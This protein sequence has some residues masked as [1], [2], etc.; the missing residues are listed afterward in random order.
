MVPTPQ[1]P[2]PPQTR[3]DDAAP[4]DHSQQTDVIVFVDKSQSYAPIVKHA[5]RIAGAFGGHII[6]LH[7]LV[8]PQDGVKPVDPVDWDIKRQ[9]TQNWL[10]SV[11]SEFDQSGHKSGQ[12]TES[13]LLEGQT[14]GQIAAH[15][16][17]RKGAVA[18]VVR[19]SQEGHQSDSVS[20]MLASASSALL[21]IPS[22]T[23]PSQIP[24]YRKILVPLDGSARAESALNMAATLA[25]ADD[26]ELVLCYVPP[27]PGVSEFDMVDDEAAQLSSQ[28]Q[29]HNA[30]AGQA[31]LT[32]VKN[33]LAH[34]GLNVSTLVVTGPDARRALIETS[35]S[36][37]ADIIVMATHGQSGHRDVS[38]GSVASHILDRS[39]IPVLMVRCEMQPSKGHAT[40]GL[41]SEG[42]RQPTGT[43]Q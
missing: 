13:V 11:A 2:Y 29:K 5:Q 7:V 24:A 40:R 8:P 14:I 15:M 22:T 20:G 42:I 33:S 21:M 18:A 12:K 26:A 10:A 27:Q 28:V 31:H 17:H 36:Q 19:S 38:A 25:Q 4:Q 23:S 6:L 35:A 41:T 39:D 3:A 30:L 34:L 1:A 16:A 43:D 32:K 9:Q 37:V